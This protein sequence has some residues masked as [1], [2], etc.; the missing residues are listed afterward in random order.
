MYLDKMSYVEA[1]EYL[2]HNDT[3]MIVTGSLENH[4]K[5]MP[6]GTDTFI[7]SKIANL[8]E[9][10][11]GK[12]IVIAPDLNYGLTEDL[13]G[14]CGTI[15]LGMDLY[16]ALLNKIFNHLYDYGFRHF[17]VINGHGGN[18][19]PIELAG[20]NLWKKGAILARIDWWLLAGQLNPVYKGGHGGG[21]ETAG[22]M[23]VDESLIKYE[24]LH[25]GENIKNDLGE[26]LP[27]GSWTSVN[28]K[29]G[30]VA[31]PRNVNHLTDNGWLTH[32]MGNDNPDRADAK[33]GKEM[34]DEVAHYIADFIPVFKKTKQ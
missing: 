15:S 7:P 33:W 10:L 14:F 31:I 16:S 21:E 24:Y 8:V 25:E 20:L 30:S 6:L 3:V 34:L 32:G 17:I 11:V 27:S 12:D 19:K 23:A 5:H 9:E 29:G 4:G 26:D 13:M 1:E 18:V 28:F 22:V 2:K